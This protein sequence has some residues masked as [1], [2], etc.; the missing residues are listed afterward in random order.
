MARLGGGQQ[1]GPFRTS[2]VPGY[3][4]E[5]LR[6][7]SRRV[8]RTA[9]RD[10]I[11]LLM[12]KRVTYTEAEAEAL[13]AQAK[14]LAD[15]SGRTVRAEAELLL[16]RDRETGLQDLRT[17]VAGAGELLV[18]IT[19]EADDLRAEFGD[20]D[21]ELAAIMA[22]R[23]AFGQPFANDPTG[24]ARSTTSRRWTASGSGRTSGNDSKPA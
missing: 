15:A 20:E 23:A 4:T 6:R 12:E 14:R 5:R 19:V 7:Y 3:R 10:V 2:S 22:T 13:V 24:C 8:A 11:G 1:T 9:R 21:G 16:S 17:K 18:A